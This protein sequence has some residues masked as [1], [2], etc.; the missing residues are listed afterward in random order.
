MIIERLI[1]LNELNWNSKGLTTDSVLAG[2]E[3]ERGEKS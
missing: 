1:E 3:K 2:A